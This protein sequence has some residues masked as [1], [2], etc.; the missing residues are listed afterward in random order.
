M[1]GPVCSAACSVDSPISHASGM[2]ESAARTKS[3]T[4]PAPVSL[5]TAIVSGARS[6][7]P[8]S[9]VRSTGKPTAVSGLS[10]SLAAA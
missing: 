3:V 2:S 5:S 10:L 9:S 7:D 1:P 8:Q 4:S 6:S